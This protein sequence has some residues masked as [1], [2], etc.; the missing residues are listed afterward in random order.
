[1]FSKGGVQE[2]E[3]AV[4]HAHGIGGAAQWRGITRA[5]KV[6]KTRYNNLRSHVLVKKIFSIKDAHFYRSKYRRQHT[7]LVAKMLF[8][9]SL[10]AE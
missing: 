10:Q 8:R 3:Q 5:P 2:L 9:P 1:M 4:Y 6:Y 7:L